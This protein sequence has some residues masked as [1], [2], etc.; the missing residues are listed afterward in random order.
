[1][2]L[3]AKISKGS[4][5][6]QIY[7]PK[8]RHGLSIGSYVRIQQLETKQETSSY[9]FYHVPVLEP[10]K[11][12]LMDQ[13]VAIIDSVVPK[14]ENILFVGSFLEPGFSFHDIDILLI[15]E[16]KA[17]INV[18]KHNAFH[19]LHVHLDLLVL[20]T[21][22][23]LRGLATDPLY[24][25]MLSKCVSKKRFLYHAKKEIN[26]KLL[27]LHLLQSKALLLNFDALTGNQKYALARNMI[28]IQLFLQSK[29]ITKEQVDKSLCT[30]FNLKTIQQLK[31]NL[32][33]KKAFLTTYK[34][35][36]DH[37]FQI[38]LRGMRHGSQ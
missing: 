5:M 8:N 21:K 26:Y 4:K 32:L 1:M 9:H 36:Y 34:K 22:T 25:M 10:L 20:T 12:Q 37:L 33:D 18:I 23:L 7:I 17:P 24:Q 16:D 31:D 35:I 28:A 27:D 38:I 13:V 15:T 30:I 14:Y 6:D 11:L 2:E 19:D 29:K 3:V